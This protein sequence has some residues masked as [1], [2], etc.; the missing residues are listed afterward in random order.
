MIQQQIRRLQGFPTQR[1]MCF[2]SQGMLLESELN[3]FFIQSEYQMVKLF[4]DR[5]HT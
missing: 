4:G 5:G 3:D 2:S 1:Q